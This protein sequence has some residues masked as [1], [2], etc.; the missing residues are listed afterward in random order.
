MANITN[1]PSL[2]PLA[3][4]GED[5]DKPMFLLAGDEVPVRVA[6]GPLHSVVLTNRGRM[7]TCGYGEK[8]ALGTGKPKTATE[9]IELKLK[10]SGKI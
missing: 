8:Y 2:S 6:C 4:R 9:F 1:L 7:F 3:S 10:N 5:E